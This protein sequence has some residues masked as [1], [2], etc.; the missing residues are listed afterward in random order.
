[1]ASPVYSAAANPG[2]VFGNVA[3][4][5]GK[6]VAAFLDLS[7]AI[8]GQVTCELVT[9]S[10]TAPA[11]ATTFS[12]Y[13]TYAA[14][15]GAPIT[16]SGAVERHHGARERLGEPRV[17]ARRPGLRAPQPVHQ[18]RRAGDDGRRRAERHR[19]PEPHHHGGHRLQLRLGRPPVPDRPDGGDPGGASSPSSTWA[20]NSV[21]SVLVSPGPS[22]YIL[23]AANAS[24][25]AVTVSVTGDKVTGVQ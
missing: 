21:Y 22:Q 23:A 7:T 3:L 18:G 10:G 16:L 24:A 14:G 8:E 13:H 2:N 20:A 6:N 1:M 15:S 11:A 4:A 12:F 19:R 5:A 9:A 25:V 17:P